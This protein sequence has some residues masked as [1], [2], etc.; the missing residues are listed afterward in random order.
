[1]ARNASPS[2]VGKFGY[3]PS[4]VQGG[5]IPVAAQSTTHPASPPPSGGSAVKRP[6]ATGTR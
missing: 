3:T 2:L 4:K 6:E 1:M 5:Y